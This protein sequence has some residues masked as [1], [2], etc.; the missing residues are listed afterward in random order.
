MIYTALDD[1]ARYESLL[2]GLADAFAMIGRLNPEQADGRIDINGEDCF[3]LMSTY[4]T[5]PCNETLWEAHR[6]YVDVQCL[7][8]GR[9]R[10][11][12]AERA[13]LTLRDDYDE[14]KDAA[15]YT[16]DIAPVSVELLPG[17]AVV[18]WPNDAHRPGI[19]IDQPAEVRK[20]VVKIRV[21]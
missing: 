3:A 7:L 13:A 9:E 4:T 15:F 18:L 17:R 21:D 20:L 6:R 16:G 5:R 10:L 1:A 19:A 2:D 12:V 8:A 14:S 11:D